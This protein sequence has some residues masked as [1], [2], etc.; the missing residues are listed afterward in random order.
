MPDIDDTFI[1]L[2]RS[3]RTAAWYK[4]PHCAQ[5][6]LHLLLEANFKDF[7]GVFN[8]TEIMVKRGQLITGRKILSSETGLSE[9]N[10]RTALKVLSM[11]EFLTIKSTSAYSLI[12]IVNYGKYQD[13]STSE[14]T[15]DQPTPNQRLTND[16]PTPNH[17]ITREQ[18][19]KGT[20]TESCSTGDALRVYKESGKTAPEPNPCPAQPTG[21]YDLPP[22]PPAPSRP[23]VP[24]TP[25]VN[26][27][28][29]TV[30]PGCLQTEFEQAWAKFPNHQQKE[31]ALREWGAAQPPL[32]KVLQSLSWQVTT[33]EFGAECP[34]FF[35]YLKDKRWE[36]ELP[37]AVIEEQQR[38]KDLRKKRLQNYMNA[39]IELSPARAA[40]VLT[41]NAVEFKDD[42]N[43]ARAIAHWEKKQKETTK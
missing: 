38:L 18:G 35:Y 16:Q 32:K 29:G 27:R 8:G 42:P 34:I 30:V 31:R 15:N 28:P 9:Q 33:E 40:E 23:V 5:L 19:N 1:T 4:H 7:K 36:D 2:H 12:T 21:A 20:K 25:Q 6:A 10:I 43:V 41:F 14:S 17:N 26:F 39:I 13:K 24:P 37:P 11:C 22:V 3:F